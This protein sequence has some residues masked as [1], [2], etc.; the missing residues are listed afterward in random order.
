MNRKRNLFI[1]FIALFAAMHNPAFGM[2]RRRQH[3]KFAREQTE[4]ASK[5]RKTGINGTDMAP[6]YLC[7]ACNET[8]DTRETMHQHHS[9]HHEGAGHI[10]Y[11]TITQE[12]PYDEDDFIKR[13]VT[14]LYKH[15][16]NLIQA[17]T[18]AS[19]VVSGRP[20]ENYLPRW[21]ELANQVAENATLLNTAK[22]FSILLANHRRRLEQDDSEESEED[23]EYFLPQ[24]QYWNDDDDE[25]DEDDI[26]QPRLRQPMRTK[27]KS[28]QKR[29]RKKVVLYDSEEEEEEE[30]SLAEPGPKITKYMSITGM[31][32]IEYLKDDGLFHCNVC[33]YKNC[34]TFYLRNHFRLNPTHK[35]HIVF[36]YLPYKKGNRY[37]C[38]HK[39]C[40]EK[41]RQPHGLKQHFG[42]LPHHKDYDETKYVPRIP[43]R[44]SQRRGRK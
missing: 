43:R 13:K 29:E 16:G 32:K 7:L 26:P 40:N 18:L 44:R 12:T 9:E 42:R 15:D 25:E 34:L 22:P 35:T 8:F 39:D 37:C 19:E 20:G 5:R 2:K 27:R 17:I 21:M 1:I 10:K 23:D 11:A 30:D 38:P 31:Y 6:F 28:R 33:A 4:P 36:S 14:R 3:V 41:Y 24:G